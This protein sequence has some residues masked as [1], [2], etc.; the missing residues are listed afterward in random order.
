MIIENFSLF[1]QR[2]SDPV[3]IGSERE[4]NLVAISWFLFGAFVIIA[5]SGIES[6]FPYHAKPLSHKTVLKAV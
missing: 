1:M 5:N 6:H 3:F 2:T 4:L